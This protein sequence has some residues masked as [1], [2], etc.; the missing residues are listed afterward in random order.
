MYQEATQLLIEGKNGLF[1]QQDTGELKPMPSASI[2]LK[3]AGGFLSFICVPVILCLRF[4]SGLGKG[5]QQFWA[6]SREANAPR[7]SSLP[8]RS[9]N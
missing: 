3:F 6:N 4:V 2:N 9:C 7:S 1:S 8:K 5:R